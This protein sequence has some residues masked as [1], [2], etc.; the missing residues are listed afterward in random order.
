MDT[1]KNA[2]SGA[3]T[4]RCVMLL[5]Q[6]KPITLAPASDQSSCARECEVPVNASYF[7]AERNCK[8]FVSTA[9]LWVKRRVSR[10]WQG[11]PAVYLCW[12]PECTPGG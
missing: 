11:L 8:I 9:L 12:C 4:G 3:V 5:E 6:F 1:P 2:L 10:C 7:R